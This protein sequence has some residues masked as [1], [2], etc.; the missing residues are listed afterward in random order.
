M[1]DVDEP[2]RYAGREGGKPF[3]KRFRF[4]NADGK[5][6]LK[7]DVNAARGEN[8]PDRRKIARMDERLS[9]GKSHAALAAPALVTPPGGIF[10]KP[11]REHAWLKAKTAR[12][13]RVRITGKILLAASTAK[14]SRKINHRFG[15]GLS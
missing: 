2:Q 3:G 10:E 7:R 9:P 1:L 5:R 15:Y 12:P 8:A 6:G 11:A 4:R 13:S 14:T